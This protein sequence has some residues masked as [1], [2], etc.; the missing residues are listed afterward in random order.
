MRQVKVWRYYCD[1][2]K[3]GGCGKAAMVKH[4][5][6]CVKNPDRECGMCRVSHGGNNSEMAELTA[7]A[8]ISL[9]R[10]REV[11]DSCPACML[12]GIVQANLPDEH[13]CHQFDFKAERDAFWKDRG[14][15]EWPY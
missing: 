11:S 10:L 2:C 1:F 14:H 3:K 9:A 7:A 5:K 13:E 15:D 12:A 8:G 4:E 6:R